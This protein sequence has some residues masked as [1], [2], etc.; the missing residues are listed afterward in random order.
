MKNSTKQ[1]AARTSLGTGPSTGKRSGSNSSG[2]GHSA[3]ERC[4]FHTL[5]KMSEPA[6]MVYSSNVSSCNALHV[7]HALRNHKQQGDA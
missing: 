2:L 1:A 7:L 4:K 3:G 6:G 5:M